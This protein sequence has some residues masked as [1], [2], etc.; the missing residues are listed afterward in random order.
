MRG[1]DTVGSYICVFV[2]VAGGVWGKGACYAG[3]ERGYH[4]GPKL[5]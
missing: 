2:C 5:L 4:L 1:Y 3:E